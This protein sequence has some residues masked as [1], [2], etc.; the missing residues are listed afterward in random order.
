MFMQCGAA[1]SV[2]VL[3]QGKHVGGCPGR[4][5]PLPHLFCARTMMA[6]ASGRRRLLIR[7]KAGPRVAP[8]R[9]WLVSLWPRL[10]WSVFGGGGVSKDAA[11]W[12]ERRRR[13][14]MWG[15][16]GWCPCPI[17]GAAPPP[18]PR[19]TLAAH[20][21]HTALPFTMR[22]SQVGRLGCAT[23]GRGQGGEDTNHYGR[24][25]SPFV[26]RGARR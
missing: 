17:R 16:R 7:T 22:T 24:S 19:P 8:R 13:S 18:R 23:K 3:I 21:R 2:A 9:A 5:F 11:T 20:A 1:L 25:R 10:C 14:V 4:A 15:G 26:L 6:G 12:S